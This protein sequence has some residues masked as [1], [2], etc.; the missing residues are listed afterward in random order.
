[1]WKAC[2]FLYDVYFPPFFLLTGSIFFS[3]RLLA[4]ICS[5]PFFSSICFVFFFQGA[6]REASCFQ[7][8]SGTR[9]LITDWWGIVESAASGECREDTLPRIYKS[10]SLG[11]KTLIPQVDTAPYGV[12]IPPAQT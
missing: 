9:R 10:N 7:L 2:L 1:M 11:T 4:G 3:V 6:S 12:G 5:K 8:A